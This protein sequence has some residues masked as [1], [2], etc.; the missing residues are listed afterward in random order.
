MTRFTSFSELAS[1]YEPPAD[2]RIPGW[3]W[4]FIAMFVFYF[5]D[6]AWTVFFQ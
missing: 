5:G 1:Y 3:A 6:W 2:N 4:A